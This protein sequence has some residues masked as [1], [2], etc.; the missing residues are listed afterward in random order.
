LAENGPPIIEGKIPRRSALKKS[1][2]IIALVCACLFPLAVQEA[3]V[4]VALGDEDAPAIIE[5]SPAASPEGIP[6]ASPPPESVVEETIPVA[7]MAIEVRPDATEAVEASP[8]PEASPAAIAE[9]SSPVPSPMSAVAIAPRTEAEWQKELEK[10]LADLE[11]SSK[12]VTDLESKIDEFTA[13]VA[14]GKA[15][16]AQ[17]GS[18]NTALAAEITELERT[19]ESLKGQRSGLIGAK[20]MDSWDF[21]RSSYSRTLASGFSG[22]KPATGKWTVTENKAVQNDGREYFAKLR[23]PVTQGKKRTL[24]SF[25]AKGGS[26]GWTGLGIHFYVSGKTVRYSY[27]EGRSLLLWFTRDPA[28]YRDD[29]THLQLYRS[30]GLVNME[31]VF[32]GKMTGSMIRPFR[33][34]ILYDPLKEY[35][36]V[37]VDGTVRIVYKTFFGIGEGVGVALRTLGPG[38]EFSDFSV[39]TEP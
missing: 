18:K 6:E 16:L 4:S 25:T 31:Q 36:L 11:A 5:L 7:D 13:E 32:S 19:I 38:C 14:I 17:S 28:A 23:M 35:L 8:S 39:K 3:G 30:D 21:D 29:D 9:A 1:L 20:A 2:A 10:A 37:A 26:K 24:Y 33:A 22:A 15:A 12:K 27:G 34:E